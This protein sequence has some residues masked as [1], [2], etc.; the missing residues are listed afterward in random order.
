M[1]ITGA[2]YI[3]YKILIFPGLLFAVV[4]GLF[5]AGLDRKL[6]P[7]VIDDQDLHDSYVIY[8]V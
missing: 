5:L 2:L 1:D 7:F 6:S 3:L 4:I 8:R